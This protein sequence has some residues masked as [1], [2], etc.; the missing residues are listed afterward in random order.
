MNWWADKLAG[1]APNPRPQVQPAPQ[2]TAPVQQQQPQQPAK[3]PQSAKETDLCPSCGSGNYMAA[4]GRQYHRC[5]DCGYPLQQSGSGIGSTSTEGPTK[6]AVQVESSGY[7]PQAI[8][9]RVE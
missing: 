4:P 7:N 2:P 1:D 8:I 9:G 3:Q 6:Q 5:Y